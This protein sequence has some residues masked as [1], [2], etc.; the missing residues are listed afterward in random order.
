MLPHYFQL[1]IEV[2]VPHFVFI[3]NQGSGGS[4]LLFGGHASLSSPYGV[5]DIVVGWP[6]YHCVTVLSLHWACYD[7][8]GRGPLLL[9][10]GCEGLSCGIH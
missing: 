2:Q 8:C 7:T 10:G 6:H 4:L 9:L 3:D 5:T 1:E